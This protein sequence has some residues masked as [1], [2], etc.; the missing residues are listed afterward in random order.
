[1]LFLLMLGALPVVA[2]ASQNRVPRLRTTPRDTLSY[3][4]AKAMAVAY[5]FYDATWNIYS[6]GTK[7]KFNRQERKGIPVIIDHATGLMWQQS[8]SATTMTH[9]EARQ[10]VGQL[11]QS[12]YAGYDDWRLPTLEEAMSLLERRQSKYKLHIEP[13]FDPLQQWIWTADK[14]GPQLVW[15]VLFDFGAAYEYLSNVAGYVRAVRSLAE[16]KPR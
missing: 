6:K 14:N 8:G 11:N 7:H 15:V 9:A 16:P 3:E 10:Y 5:G 12:R 1:M 2:L 4:Q 13:Q